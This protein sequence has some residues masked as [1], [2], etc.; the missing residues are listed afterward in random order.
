MR[1]CVNAVCRR[2]SFGGTWPQNLK[3]DSLANADIARF[4]RVVI[5]PSL[6]WVPEYKWQTI[7]PKVDKQIRV[8]AVM[9]PGTKSVEDTI[10]HCKGASAIWQSAST[11]GV[12]EGLGWT[13]PQRTQVAK[14]C[15]R[16]DGHLRVQPQTLLTRY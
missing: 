7:S 13:Q 8:F 2:S 12:M 6:P 4:L 15:A 11:G 10:G 9:Q 14:T 16:S 5:W 3:Q 1:L